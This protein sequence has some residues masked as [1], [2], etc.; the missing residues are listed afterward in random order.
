MIRLENLRLEAEMA[1]LIRRGFE[2][3]L[4][5]AAGEMAAGAAEGR[6]AADEIKNIDG[7]NK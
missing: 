7:I 1:S 4:K 5:I 2:R 6:A 3:D